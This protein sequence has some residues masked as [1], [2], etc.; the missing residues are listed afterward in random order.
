MLFLLFEILRPITGNPA[1]LHVDDASSPGNQRRNKSL[2]EM[3][4]RMP[5][6]L[7]FLH[8]PYPTQIS[9]FFEIPRCSGCKANKHLQQLRFI[10]VRIWRY[11]S[12]SR[13]CRPYLWGNGCYCY[14]NIARFYGSYVGMIPI[15]VTVITKTRFLGIYYYNAYHIPSDLNPGNMPAPRTKARTIE[16]LAAQKLMFYQA[17]V[18]TISF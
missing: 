17:P 11:K 15:P 12:S 13:I 4:A 14:Y 8:V 9:L 16:H 10:S 6:F 1:T 2:I 5:N 7:S 18:V 3:F